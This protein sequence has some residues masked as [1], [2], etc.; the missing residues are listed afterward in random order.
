MSQRLCAQNYGL[1]VTIQERTTV[2]TPRIQRT[3]AIGLVL[4]LMAALMVGYFVQLE[5]ILE[6]FCIFSFLL[7][8]E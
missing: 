4:A 7:C 8:I 5:Q 1:K 3:G 2:K 6:C